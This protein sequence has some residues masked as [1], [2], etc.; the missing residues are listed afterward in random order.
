MMNFTKKLALGFLTAAILLSLAACGMFKINRRVV[1][2]FDGDTLVKAVSA[3]EPKNVLPPTI[4]RE[5]YV[6]AF[7]REKDGDGA[8]GEDYDFGQENEFVAVW[9]PREYSVTYDLSGGENGDNPNSYTIEDSFVL[10][11][12]KK[13]GSE[14]LGWTGGG[15]YTPRKALAVEKGTTGELSFKAVF[16]AADEN[17]LYFITNGGSEKEPVTST[18]GVFTDGGTVTRAGYDFDGWFYDE[19][20]TDK[21]VFPIVAEQKITTLYA[22]FTPITYHVYSVDGAF[23]T[24][25]YNV[26]SPEFTVPEPAKTGYVFDGL[27]ERGSA[28]IEK[29]FTIGAG[30]TK[31]YFLEA[32]FTAIDY[33]ITFETFGGSEIAPVVARYGDDISSL[34]Q[35][36][37]NYCEFTGW[38]TDEDLTVAFALST[39]PAEDLVL[40]AGWYSDHIH[41]LTYSAT[42]ESAK[43][44]ANVP[45]GDRIAGEAVALSAPAYA[46]GAVFYRW[47]RSGGLY[48][49]DNELSFEM[50]DGNVELSAEYFYVETVSYD[51]SESG[52]LEIIS[53]DV[54]EK[55]DGAGI[56][57]G[58][59]A[60]NG[61]TAS[62]KESFLKTLSEGYHTLL[63][64]TSSGGEYRLLK[65]VR[66]SASLYG[67]KI[68]YDSAY[69]AV[70]LCAYGADGAALE[71]SLNGENYLPF[72]GETIIENYDKSRNNTVIVRNADDSNDFV[73]VRK[74]GYTSENRKYME[75]SFEF[76]GRTYDA[77]VESEEEFY[78]CVNYI[79]QVYAPLNREESSHAGG[80]SRFE[81]GC[82]SAFYEEIEDSSG[83]RRYFER[84]LN[85]NA[86]YAPTY[87]YSR[88][89]SSRSVTL[90]VNFDSKQLNSETSDEVPDVISDAQNLLRGS[91]RAEDYDDFKSERFS[92][93]Q[94]VRTLYE[95]EGL[96][97]G[98]RPVFTEESGAAYEV[99]AEAKNILRKYVDDDMSDFEK[100]VAIYDYLALNVTY[101]HAV[102]EYAKKDDHADIGKFAAF[103]SYGALINKIAVCD[104]IASAFE[105]LCKTEGIECV[106]VMGSAGGGGHAWNKVRIGGQWYNVD[107]TWSHIQIGNI[108]YV[109]HRY[110]C[111]DEYAFVSADH[112]ENGSLVEEEKNIANVAVSPLNYYNAEIAGASDLVAESTEEIR[113][114][115]AERIEGGATAVEVLVKDGNVARAVS[116]MQKFFV[117]YDYY[118][119]GGGVYLI[120]QNKNF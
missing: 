60:V 88:D 67:A 16:A 30:S 81:F 77:F 62:I 54:I 49:Y 74:D 90:T 63:I 35:P 69:P 75:S 100:V 109:S 31:D 94:N 43:I 53:G 107:A 103:T 5:G 80:S 13:D 25:E 72:A 1:L 6:L 41:S 20:L 96:P 22:G 105:I 26:E 51:L 29:D 116:R 27:S 36:S 112:E 59:Y 85:G 84:A 11:D 104:G 73:V 65:I 68:D 52:D 47:S 3:I 37:R 99:Y 18:D 50:P 7:W 89:N 38:F 97:F 102:A 2:F 14:F 19:T 115:V 93:E 108:N 12:A 86:P 56:R 66:S 113:E 83:A 119:V 15:V 17:Y 4:E 98:V 8:F 117:R 71:Y 87:S 48:S 91:S 101:D 42:A 32:H 46:D 79:L 111:V 23:D 110:L 9:E 118:E 21:A 92:A 58:E 10:A 95:L 40:Y 44:V 106:E 78:V 82:S 28:V 70:K 64:T 45:C 120:I 24:I 76:G 114:I 39:M 34:P 61:R 57:S 55:V 33:T